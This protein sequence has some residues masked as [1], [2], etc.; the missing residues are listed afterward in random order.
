MPVTIS[1]L[2][3][4]SLPTPYPSLAPSPYHCPCHPRVPAWHRSPITT[5]VPVTL[6]SP[7]RAGLRGAVQRGG[8]PL[9]A[10]GA[11]E[12]LV[13]V[14]GTLGV[15][16]VPGH[17]AIGGLI[18]QPARAQRLGPCPLLL[19][20]AGHSLRALLARRE[21]REQGQGWHGAGTGVRGCRGAVT[22]L[23]RSWHGDRPQ[24][25]VGGVGQTRRGWHRT[26]GHRAPLPARGVGASGCWGAA[27]AG[28]GATASG[29]A[30]QCQPPGPPAPG[31]SVPLSPRGHAAGGHSTPRCPLPR[32]SA[33]HRRD[34]GM[35]HP[36]PPGPPTRGPLTILVTEGLQEKD[37]Q[38]QPGSLGTCHPSPAAP[39]R[40]RK[41]QPQLP[42]GDPFYSTHQSLAPF[43][44]TPQ[45]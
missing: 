37:R 3:P 34:P 42:W 14:G 40:C 39:S 7:T 17:V 19:L 36:P 31:Q 29:T 1:L 9:L 25:G 20:R 38:S 23:A 27:G 4:L 35:G 28:H 30:G 6:V 15:P 26:E 43:L 24:L 44:G 21:L 18:L 45:C 5:P 10:Q 22:G 11:L 16:T 41:P 33:R 8:Q 2:P 12:P 13:G 32:A